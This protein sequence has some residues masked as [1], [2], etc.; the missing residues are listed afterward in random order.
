MRSH[1]PKVV[2]RYVRALLGTIDTEEDYRGVSRDLKTMDE[3]LGAHGELRAGLETLLLSGEEK[4]EIIGSLADRVKMHPKTARFLRI[5]AGENRLMLLRDIIGNLE[6]GWLEKQGVE[7]IKVFSSLPLNDELRESLQ[8]KLSKGIGRKVLL[9]T[10]VD[11]SLIAG[12]KIQRGFQF[13]D[14]SL[15]GNLEKLRMSLIEEGG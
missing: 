10:E 3:I 7:R 1:D 15:Q 2:K 14:F 8:R 11:S 13:Y 6:T 12:I 5:L 9:K 4:E